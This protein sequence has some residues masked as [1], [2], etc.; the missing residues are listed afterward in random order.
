[1]KHQ[2]AELKHSGFDGEGHS[3]PTCSRCDGVMAY[4]SFEDL[5][6]DTGA[7]HFDGWRCLTCGNI[8]DPLI[9]ENRKNKTGPIH[10]KTRKRLI[11]R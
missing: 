11:F 4:E 10:S 1:M 6:D 8:I 3:A 5:R 7:I 2:V 9:L